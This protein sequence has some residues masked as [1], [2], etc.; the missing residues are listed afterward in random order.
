[1][2]GRSVSSLV[3]SGRA[4]HS[5]LTPAAKI[6]KSYRCLAAPSA[7]PAAAR[8]GSNHAGSRAFA[9]GSGPAGSWPEQSFV[10]EPAWEP[11]SIPRPLLVIPNTLE[12]YSCL[13]E[14]QR[15]LL[16]QGVD[17]KSIDDINMHFMDRFL[18][19]HRDVEVSRPT[20]R[21]G[22]AAMRGTSPAG[23]KR[24]ATLAGVTTPRRLDLASAGARSTW[25]AERPLQA[26]SWEL[27]PHACQVVQSRRAEHH[28]R[29][30]LQVTTRLTVQ[31]RW[32]LRGGH[33]DSRIREHFV[34]FEMPR[35]VPAQAFRISAI[36]PNLAPQ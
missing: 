10:F 32:A 17:L 21:G 33:D 18:E 24:G 1:M 28:S 26:Q 2:W 13:K 22:T 34:V 8:D 12:T 11:G 23:P 35:D 14:A 30:W 31:E 29:D 5:R 20:R 25:A 36:Q 6:T 15:L 27:T 16:G 19:L 3:G 7:A 4:L 9:P